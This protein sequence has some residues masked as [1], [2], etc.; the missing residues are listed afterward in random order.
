[1]SEEFYQLSK[2]KTEF[3][4]QLHNRT[5]TAILIISI[6]YIIALVLLV[7]MLITSQISYCFFAIVIPLLVFL[8]LDTYGGI[9]HVNNHYSFKQTSEGISIYKKRRDN[10]ASYI[11]VFV[12]IFYI[13]SIIRLISEM[14]N[15]KII[16]AELISRSK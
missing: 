11:W 16:N 13:S 7:V 15:L 5:I 14:R 6:V 1:M 9:K 2:L 12:L 8:W 4:E 10:Y 3:I